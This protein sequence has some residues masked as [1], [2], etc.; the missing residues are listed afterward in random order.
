MKA[1]LLDG[2]GG[3]DRLRLADI[4]EPVPA[5]GE[6]WAYLSCGTWSLLG[7]ETPEPICTKEALAE[8]YTN[9]LGLGGSV[10]F[11]KNIVGLWIVQECRRSWLAAGQDLSDLIRRHPADRHADDGQGQDRP[12][13]HGVDVG[14]GV[15]RGYPSEGERIVH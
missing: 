15:G 8:N 2:L 1:W 12:A 13:P 10:R 11:L 6:G 5:E 14:K 9:E 7:V 3:L 4:A